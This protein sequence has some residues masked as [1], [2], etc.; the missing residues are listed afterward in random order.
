M[1]KKIVIGIT[2]DDVIRDF[3]F[4]FIKLYNE[5]YPSKEITGDDI[6]IYNLQH[7][8][9][10]KEHALD[11]IYSEVVLELFGLGNQTTK[12]CLLD[13]NKINEIFEEEGFELVII[14]NEYGKSK[15]ASIYFLGAN[16][17]QLNKIIFVKNNQE[18]FDNCEYIVT[19]N[20]LLF[21]KFKE[22]YERI[23]LID[24]DYNKQIEAKYR[25]SKVT[26]LPDLIE[27]LKIKI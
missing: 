22:E 11:F 17:C 8:F 25:L 14:S 27:E 19:T 15:S 6:D 1:D 9:D 23:I 21:D 12:N 7:L 10:S 13:L 24:K 2:L 4:Q 26:K 16:M 3:S 18:L 5:T 20:Y